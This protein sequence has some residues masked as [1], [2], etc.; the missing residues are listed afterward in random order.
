MRQ[1]L[2]K[3]TIWSIMYICIRDP[4]DMEKG[5]AVELV[6]QE[7]RCKKWKKGGSHRWCR[8]N[9]VM[10]QGGK[11]QYGCKSVDVEVDGI[12]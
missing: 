12:D 1:M 4:R 2:I 10:R 11:N 7:L 9:W 5:V 6:T 3:N 8:N